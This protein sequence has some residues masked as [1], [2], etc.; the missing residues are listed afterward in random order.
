MGRARTPR[1][2]T[3]GNR[4]PTKF[5]FS[6]D[7]ASD[8]IS[9]AAGHHTKVRNSLL[10]LR[11]PRERRLSAETKNLKLGQAVFRVHT[12]TRAQGQ[13]QDDC[14]P[15]APFGAFPLFFMLPGPR[16]PRG[17]GGVA[18]RSSPLPSGDR[19]EAAWKVLVLPGP[20]RL[21]APCHDVSLRRYKNSVA[22]DGMR[23]I[24]AETVLH[25]EL[26]RRSAEREGGAVPR[27]ALRRR[28]GPRNRP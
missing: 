1:G 21:S 14:F 8:N 6:R 13:W 15:C 20:A 26:V 23:L 10:G 17:P 24:L 19:P 28:R 5:S 16:G 4:N 2:G 3:A 9:P 11:A 22:H 25:R 7:F 18:C 27:S 12:H